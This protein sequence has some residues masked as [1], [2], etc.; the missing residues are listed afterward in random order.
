MTTYNSSMQYTIGTALERAR[1]NGH[2]VEVLVE[3]DWICGQVVAGDGQG[4]VLEGRTEEHS[5]VRLER[6]SAVKVRSGSPFR[7]LASVP[8]AP[9]KQRPPR[10]EDGAVPMPPP[11]R[12]PTE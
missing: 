2:L 10:T 1:E 9:G 6:I 7:T 3:G 4:I 5:I 11:M 12:A 8:D